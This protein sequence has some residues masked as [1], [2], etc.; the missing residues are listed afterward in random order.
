IITQ[1]GALDATLTL[2]HLLIGSRYL[3]QLRA[4]RSFLRISLGRKFLSDLALPRRWHAHKRSPFERVRVLDPPANLA[5]NA[6]A[7]AN[8]ISAWPAFE[9]AEIAD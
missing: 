9:K 4:Q 3:A 7:M 5:L 2:D 1:R 6:E 8:L